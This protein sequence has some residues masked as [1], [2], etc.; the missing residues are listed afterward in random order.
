MYQQENKE[1]K[2]LTIQVLRAWAV[3]RPTARYVEYE[4]LWH[5]KDPATNVL[6][7]W[8]LRLGADSTVTVFAAE[9]VVSWFGGKKWLICHFDEDSNLAKSDWSSKRP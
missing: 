6:C 1:D 9:P 5:F 4:S 3:S 2:L 7:D 8:E